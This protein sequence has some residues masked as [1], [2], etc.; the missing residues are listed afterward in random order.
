MADLTSDAHARALGGIARAASVIALGNVTS[1][2]LGLVRETVKARLFGAGGHVDALNIALIVPIQIYELVTGGLV[3]S[4]LVPV[5]SE[6]ADPERRPELWRLLSSLLAV[7]VVLLSVAVLGFEAV[8]PLL[9]RLIAGGASPEGQALTASL[10][11]LTLPAVACLSLSGVF[12]GLLYSLRR[13]TLPAFTAAIF[14]LTMVVL[15]ILLHRRL[16]VVAMA[17]GLL[18]GAAMQ[19]LIQWPA[20]RDVRLSLRLDLKHPG[21]GRIARLYGPIIVGLLIAQASVYIGLGLAS[22]TGEGGIAWMGYATTLYQF[23]LGLVSTAISLAVLPSLAR[24]ANDPTA[25]R[26][27]L[28]QGMNL[29]VVLIAPATAGLLVLAQPIVGLLFERGQFTP[30]DT[31]Q[32]ARVL[33]VFLFGLSFAALDQ[34]LIFA[35]Y[36]RQD[37]F[38]PAAIGVLSVGLYLVV[39]LSLIRPLGLLGLM[40]ADSIKQIFHASVTGWILSRRLRQATGTGFTSFAGFWAAAGKAGLGAG[41]LGAGAWAALTA[42]NAF[43]VLPGTLG[44]LVGVLVPGIIGAGLYAGCVSVLRIPELELLWT[45]VRGRWVRAKATTLP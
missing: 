2:V 33:Q 17:L 19:I 44:H 34:L 6:Y 27:T 18:A 8:A 26:L 41:L 10:L 5:F 28:G 42:V 45:V 38:T 25:F 24:Q 11:R 30:A 13:F 43:A 1:R 20:L 22:R 7:S 40:V 37:T 23:P 4:A 35:F 36:A 3:N 9:A 29:V 12:T 32:T 31:L 14:N 15:A 16:G 39:A 21:L